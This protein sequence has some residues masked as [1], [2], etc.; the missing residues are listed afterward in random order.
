MKKHSYLIRTG[1]DLRNQVCD[2][3]VT[4]GA[5]QSVDHYWIWVI[6]TWRFDDSSLTNLCIFGNVHNEKR[7]RER[8][9]EKVTGGGREAS[10]PAEEKPW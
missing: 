5:E 4:Q 9:V 1:K 3:K 6:G 2:Q 8:E 7:T 10:S